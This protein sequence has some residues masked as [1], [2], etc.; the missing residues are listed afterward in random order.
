MGRK[1]FT[2]NVTLADAETGATKDIV[3]RAYWSPEKVERD[4]I[5]IAAA[6]TASYEKKRQLIPVQVELVT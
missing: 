4:S 3:F 2:W 6:A 5:G 1:Q